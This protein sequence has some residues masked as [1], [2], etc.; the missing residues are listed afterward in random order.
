MVVEKIHVEPSCWVKYIPD[1]AVCRIFINSFSFIVP[2]SPF[3]HPISLR[4]SIG[5]RL[6][7]ST[8]YVLYMSRILKTSERSNYVRFKI[9]LVIASH[10]INAIF[11]NVIPYFPHHADLTHN[12]HSNNSRWKYLALISGVYS[13]L[14]RH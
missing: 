11:Y 10:F 3:L 5:Q 7:Y 2:R 14:Q 4:G 13:A 1:T 9:Y 6:T 8:N 12:S